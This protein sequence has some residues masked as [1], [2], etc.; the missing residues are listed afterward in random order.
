MAGLTNF[1]CGLA[2]GLGVAPDFEPL[3]LSQTRSTFRETTR[4]LTHERGAYLPAI[5]RRPDEFPPF[6]FFQEK[7]GFVPNIFRAQTL[8]PDVL[9]AEAGVIRAVL[10]TEDVLTRVQKECILL[11]VSA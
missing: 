9:E 7:F 8:R 4:D 11:V 10:L 2:T 1:L 3:M 5:E 6:A